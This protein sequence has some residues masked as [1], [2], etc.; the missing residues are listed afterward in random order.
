M[1]NKID[2]VT[3][4][5]AAVTKFAKDTVYGDL[6][7]QDNTPFTTLDQRD[8]L[9]ADILN[10]TG[11]VI[12]GKSVNN[13]TNYQMVFIN[14]DT[15]EIIPIADCNTH[16]FSIGMVYPILNNSALAWVDGGTKYYY[17]VVKAQM[18]SLPKDWDGYFLS[19]AWDYP[20]PG[21]RTASADVKVGDFLYYNF[22]I[23]KDFYASHTDHSAGIPD[24]ITVALAHGWSPD[25]ALVYSAPEGTTLIG[26][27]GGGSS[28]VNGGIYYVKTAAT[29]T[30]FTISS[31]A[32]GAGATIQLSAGGGEV[33]QAFIATTLVDGVITS[34]KNRFTLFDS[35]A[36]LSQ[37]SPSPNTTTLVSDNEGKNLLL[38]RVIAVTNAEII[39]NFGVFNYGTFVTGSNTHGQLA[40]VAAEIPTA[41]GNWT[42]SHYGYTNRIL[43]IP[44]A[45]DD[46]PTLGDLIEVY[47]LNGTAKY[48][49]STNANSAALI[50]VYIGMT[51]STRYVLNRGLWNSTDMGSVIAG[52]GAATNGQLL[53]DGAGG[54]ATA[55][56]PAYAHPALA[57][58]IKLLGIVTNKTDT[59]VNVYVN[60]QN[61]IN[62]AIDHAVDIFLG[63]TA[64]DP[65]ISNLQCVESW[66]GVTVPTNWGVIGNQDLKKINSDA[67]VQIAH[68]TS[69][70][71]P[72]NYSSLDAGTDI[73]TVLATH[74]WAAGQ[75]VGMAATGTATIPGLTS[76]N[77]YFIKSPSGATF[78]LSLTAGGGTIDIGAFSGSGT[79]TF[80]PVA[81]NWFAISENCYMN[82]MNW[83]KGNTGSGY[84]DNYQVGQYIDQQASQ[85]SLTSDCFYTG[86]SV[87]G[88]F[89]NGVRTW[90]SCQETTPGAN[91]GMTLTSIV[92]TPSS[93]PNLRTIAINSGS[94]IYFW[95][96][97]L[98]DISLWFKPNIPW[99]GLMILAHD[100]V[101]GG[102]TRAYASAFSYEGYS[103]LNTPSVTFYNVSLITKGNWVDDP[104]W[105]V[106]NPG[107][108]IN[109][110]ATLWKMLPIYAG[111]IKL[112][113][114]GTATFDKFRISPPI[115]ATWWA[116]F[117]KCGISALGNSAATGGV[118]DGGMLGW[119]EVADST[120]TTFWNGATEKLRLEIDY[121]FDVSPASAFDQLDLTT[122]STG[123]LIGCV[124]RPYPKPGQALTVTSAGTT[125]TCS[126]S[127]VA[128]TTNEYELT[129]TAGATAD[130]NPASA[131]TVGAVDST[132][133]GY[134]RGARLDLGADSGLF[135]TSVKYL[136]APDDF[137]KQRIRVL[138]N[139]DLTLTA[140]SAKAWK[141]YTTM[142]D[143]VS[144]PSLVV[145]SDKEVWIDISKKSAYRA[146]GM[147]F[148]TINADSSDSIELTVAQSNFNDGVAFLKNIFIG[149]EAF[150]YM[151]EGEKVQFFIK[152]RAFAPDTITIAAVS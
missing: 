118:T 39:L 40:D 116:D 115:A 24:T 30:T 69:E 70:I 84:Y 43:A 104:S 63:Q 71:V 20:T 26:I 79:I 127:L 32:G 10:R 18:L 44:I 85:T 4:P 100:I 124:S 81:N 13:F 75:I 89:R 34:V 137:L 134:P 15:S 59:T 110:T 120:A 121:A 132:V 122:F 58:N 105:S 48:R 135:V 37:G 11:T 102:T 74:N 98:Q 7:G 131:F 25:Q 67:S 86:P 19:S 125:E 62:K 73:I 140:P 136:S 139:T 95:K 113:I 53:W 47:N 152:P 12:V 93:D 97:I 68:I 145:V 142:D 21:V 14:P 66:A 3:N 109:N 45:F 146:F 111:G 103:G 143:I 96:D 91:D 147:L 61:G 77:Y 23:S 83:D 41:P 119:D 5:D 51:G 22:G 101:D 151:T 28:L 114:N 80:T 148:S 31:S 92:Y 56:R 35:T 129:F 106:A 60:P 76:G 112:K 9:I 99:V 16:N 150:R 141:V 33:T 8:L 130:T 52:T 6:I 88:S 107:L 36:D 49:I 65:S 126:W 82:D 38:G 138:S 87:K 123:E 27:D 46:S 108:F 117:K 133:Y 55:T 2:M 78:Q 50:G 57:D 90:D 149:T 1:A 128:G 64:P 144:A 17:V 54:T 29:P 72:Q 94:N 42:S